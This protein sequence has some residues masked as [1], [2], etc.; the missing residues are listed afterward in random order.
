LN[1]FNPSPYYGWSFY[2]LRIPSGVTL[3]GVTGTK[4]LQGAGGRQNIANV[5]GCT[6]IENAVI[7]VGNHYGANAFQDP[8]SNGGFY[9]LKATS[10]GSSSVTLSTASQASSFAAGDYVAIYEYTSGD[11]LPGQMAQLTAVN[12]ST[13]QLTLADPVLRSFSSPSIANVTS[14]AAHDIALNGVIVQ[15]ATPLAVTETFNFTASNDQFLSDTSIGGGNIYELQFNTMEHFKLSGNIIAS[16]NGPY[17]HQE[18]GQ[19]DSQ[20]GTWSGNTFQDESVGFGEY[21]GNIT[22]TNNHI[23]LHPDGTGPDGVTLGG[24]NVVF[25]GN[26][27]HTVGNQTDSSG[28]GAI[29]GDVY[30]PASYTSYTGKIQITNN[31]IQCVA[32]GN[33]C[34]VLVGQGT[35]ASGNTITATGSATGVYVADSSAQVTNNTLKIGNGT[36]I[37]LYTPPVDAATVAGNSLTGTGRFGIHV[38]SPPRPD[39]GGYKILNNTIIGF[40]TPISIDMSLHRGTILNNNSSHH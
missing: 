9:S 30:G 4:L 26:D 33:N 16:I 15:G 21:A 19:R 27:V 18:L 39:S 35:V 8:A 14:L 7:V 20:N 38:G 32:D 3:Q 37:L 40:A 31:T 28:W 25:S 12:A 22:M 1:S 11:V 5:P 24:M 10:I 36:G 13:G 2:N 34:L 6:W 17:I 29:V 23:Y